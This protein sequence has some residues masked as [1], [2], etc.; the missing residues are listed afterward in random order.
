MTIEKWNVDVFG[1][2]N[3]YFNFIDENTV[4]FH[5][6]NEF[7][8]IKL[9][10]NQIQIIDFMYTTLGGSIQEVVGYYQ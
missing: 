8:T 7:C 6:H 10:D 2:F 9:I 5:F 3:C 1:Q 4:N